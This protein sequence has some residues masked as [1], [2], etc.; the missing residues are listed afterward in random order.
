MNRLSEVQTW[1][2]TGVSSGLGRAIAV[3]AVETGHNVV[4]TVR[5][6]RDKRDFERTV[7]DRARGFVLDLADHAALEKLVEYSGAEF[8]SRID[9]LVNN[10]GYGLAGAI[11]EI[12][13]A[14]I[15]K[16]FEVNVF[17]VF[18]LCQLVLPHMRNKRNGCIINMS[19]TG[20]VV[21]IPGLGIYS[22]TKFAIEGFSEAL[23]G[24]VSPLGI[25]VLLIEPGGFR[26]AWNGR[27]M[28][29]TSRPIEDYDSTAGEFRRFITS[30]HGKLPGDPGE[31]GRVIVR[32]AA[33]DKTP[34]RFVLGSDAYHLIKDKLSSRLAEVQ[35]QAS[36]S[37]QTDFDREYTSLLPEGLLK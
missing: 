32:A 2:V 28:I 23:S 7:G 11:E 8:G 6:E 37:A 9:V 13:I 21:G 34:F 5:S 25:R 33:E 36:Q 17:S 26:T 35:R 31:A 22:S 29:H 3:A 20:G 19:S 27:S 15:R 1:L 30:L 4:G 12:E 14:N 24:E 10:A 16:Q 18:R